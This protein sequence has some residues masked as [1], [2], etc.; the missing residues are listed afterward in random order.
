MQVLIVEDDRALAQFVQKGLSL[1]GHDVRWAGDGEQALRMLEDQLPDLMVLDLGLPG[2]DGTEVLEALRVRC[3]DTAILV[4]TGRG[5]VKDRVHC[6]DLGA[7]DV[8]LKPFSL[9]E[10][11]ARCRALLRRR[12]RF[13]DP[14]LRF[15]SIE[16]DRLE[17]RV[18]Y[19]GHDLVLTQKEYALLEVLLRRQGACCSRTAL[20]EE[21]WHGV[22]E[23]GTNIVDVYI[24][25]LRRKLMQAR[26]DDRT[27]GSAIETV[28]GSGYR[29]RSE[30]R[31]SNGP[32][33]GRREFDR[34]MELPRGA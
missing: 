8:M 16:M 17:R 7:D 9:H 24:T 34:P 14:V 13:A 33:M 32:S 10:L 1:E 22:T 23:G 6:L 27:L 21:V 20:L 12:E 4:L 30:R 26:P 25:Y 31:V 19:G 2:R 29:L 11:L 15:G 5:Q 28:R 3:S 18:R